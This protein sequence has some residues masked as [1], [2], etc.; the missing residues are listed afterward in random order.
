MTPTRDGAGALLA[1]LLCLGA[2]AHP[3][4][5]LT[6]DTAACI[7]DSRCH[8]TLAVA[9]RVRGFG[10]PENSIAAIARAV[11]AGM[12]VVDVDL[13]ASRDGELFLLHDRTLARTTTLRGPIENA[14]ADALANARL[15]NGEP[16]P[17]FKDAYAMA[18]GRIMLSVEFKV[19]VV[20]AVADWIQGHGSFDDLI[21]FVATGQAMQSAAQAKRR[22]PHMIV[23]VR[24]LDR[25]VTVESTQAVFGRLPEI[26]HTDRVSAREVASLHAL[27]VKVWMNAAPL[28]RYVEPIRSLALGQLL[29]TNLDFI[30]TDMP[31]P[32]ARRIAAR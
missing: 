15:K 3:A 12:A 16:L 1:G 5:P 27:G 17:R 19:D 26:F 21:F 28:K 13:R 8:V 2:P 23:M 9:H 4:W 20:E 22:Y 14:N 7:R 18:R 25:R 32:V 11:G 30:L 10:E 24:L 31:V 29:A 6:T